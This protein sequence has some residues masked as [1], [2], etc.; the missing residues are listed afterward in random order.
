[1]FRNSKSAVHTI[2]LRFKRQLEIHVDEKIERLLGFTVGDEGKSILVHNKPTVVQV[3]E[4]F[5][6]SGYETAKR[7]KPTA[8]DLSFGESSA[9]F[10]TTPYR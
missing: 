10:Y 3:L 2:I 6:M 9:I 8:L 4:H 7:P 5:K 1:M